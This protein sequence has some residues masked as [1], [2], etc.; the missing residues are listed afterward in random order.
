MNQ[1]N[2]LEPVHKLNPN[3]LSLVEYG[4]YSC[5][6]CQELQHVLSRVLPQFPGIIT[7][8]FRHFPNL[9]HPMAFLMALMA[10]AARQQGKFRAMHTVLF[11]QTHP[12][13]I[14]AVPVLA[15]SV[16][17]NVDWFLDDLHNEKLKGQVWADIAQGQQD[18]VMQTPTLF[19]GSHRLHGKLT[20]ARLV[21]LIKQY[22]DRSTSI[23]TVSPSHTLRYWSTGRPL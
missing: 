12:I 11:A 7:V 20:Q 4:D 23:S 6:R 13:S 14:Q 18:G 3:E 2:Q 10:E 5:R 8:Q 17:L 21:P 1:T 19:L 22:I 9:S 15:Q 16:G